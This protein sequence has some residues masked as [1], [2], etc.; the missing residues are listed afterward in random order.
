MGPHPTYE[1]KVTGRGQKEQSRV[2]HSS[3]CPL[4]TCDSESLWETPRVGI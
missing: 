1:L 4:R 3:G 2:E